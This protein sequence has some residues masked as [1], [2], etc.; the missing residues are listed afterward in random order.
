MNAHRPLI[1][2]VAYHLAE[3]RVARWPEGGYGVPKP[4]LDALRRAGRANGDPS[5]GEEGTPE[6]ILDPFDGLLPGRRW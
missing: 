2:V 3:D 6:E 5:P 4:Y 1:A